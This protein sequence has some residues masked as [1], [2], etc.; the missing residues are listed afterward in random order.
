MSGMKSLIVT[1]CAVLSALALMTLVVVQLL[2]R[3]ETRASFA[4]LHNDIQEARYQYKVLAVDSQGNDRTGDGA[5]KFTSITPNERELSSLG[6]AGWEVVASYLE[7]ETAYPNFGK[8]EY[9]TGLQPNI[10]PQR[11]VM[12]LRHR[13]G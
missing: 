4:T 12:I 13:V 3:N 7:M 2:V 10:R 8:A 1:I 11:V 9:V 5:M 6:A